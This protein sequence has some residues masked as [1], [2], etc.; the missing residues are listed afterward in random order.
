MLYLS[1][2]DN[3]RPATS[4]N[5]ANMSDSTS[6]PAHDKTF[7][8]VINGTPHTLE[9]ELVSYEILG[10]LAFPGH[11]PA[12]IFTVAYKNAIT[13]HGGSG[14]LVAGE[15]VKVKKKGTSFDVRLTT[16]S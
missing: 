1:S 10:G 3:R 11:D 12:A 15:S 7:T 14:T 9:R 13:G 6:S 16:R 4:T 5:G 2:P 8:V